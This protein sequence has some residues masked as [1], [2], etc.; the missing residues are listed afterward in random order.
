MSCVWKKKNS[1]K[2]LQCHVTSLGFSSLPPTLSARVMFNTLHMI[3]VHFTTVSGCDDVT[4][5][6]YRYPAEPVWTVRFIA[7]LVKLLISCMRQCHDGNLH[8][9]L[10]LPYFPN[11]LT[12]PESVR[13]LIERRFIAEWDAG[14][15]SCLAVHP[16][17]KS[18][19]R[20]DALSGTERMRQSAFQAENVCK[21]RK[22]EVRMNSSVTVSPS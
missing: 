19:L 8:Y 1:H 22:R 15:A 4:L 5:P 3:F 11:V 14:K 18:L 16:T 13:F 10:V 2:S 21:W 17:K 12:S 6:G 9:N 7:S 20:L